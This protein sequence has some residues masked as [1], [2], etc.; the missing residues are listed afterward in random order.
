MDR[1]AAD[2]KFGRG[3]V[4]PL[5]Q[6]EFAPQL[7]RLSEIALMR[8]LAPLVL[9]VE[10]R[11]GPG[12]VPV[13]GRSFRE[14]KICTLIP[15]AIHELIPTIA[16]A[17]DASAHL[18]QP[19]G[20]LLA[21]GICHGGGL[22]PVGPNREPNDAQGMLARARREAMMG[23][24]S[25]NVSEVFAS[26]ELDRLEHIPNVGEM[27]DVGIVAAG[28]SVVALRTVLDDEGRRHRVPLLA[29][30]SL[31]PIN[32]S[33]VERL[34]E[35]CRRVLVFEPGG[36][37]LE[38]RVLQVAERMRRAARR[39]AEVLPG[40]PVGLPAPANA[41]PTAFAHALRRLDGVVESSPEPMSLEPP[42][43]GSSVGLAGAKMAVMRALRSLPEGAAIDDESAETLVVVGVDSN[44]FL[45][46]IAAHRDQPACFIGLDF[47]GEL[48]RMV[49]TRH[50][51]LTITRRT[52]Q[53]LDR[54]TSDITLAGR[55]NDI[56]VVMLRDEDPPRW[57]IEATRRRY[58]DLDRLGYA[59]RRRIFLPLRSISALGQG[60]EALSERVLSHRI[61]TAS[62]LEQETRT[63]GPTVEFRPLLQLVQVRREASPSFLPGELPEPPRPRLSD[64]RAFRL[65]FAGTRGP[66]GGLICE[67][68]ARAA[69][70]D[71]LALRW[72]HDS[73]ACGPGW[74]ASTQIVLSTTTKEEGLSPRIP[75]GCA[76]LLLGVE[77]AEA[78]R[79]VYGRIAKSDRTRAIVNGG[80]LRGDGTD[81]PWGELTPS[82]EALLQEHTQLSL[83]D[84]ATPARKTFGTDRAMD[85]MLL[86]FAYQRGEIPLRGAALQNAL[87]EVEREGFGR[88]E[89]AFLFGRSVACGGG[90]IESAETSS[91]RHRL[92]LER[93]LIKGGRWGQR[94]RH[95]VRRV[96]LAF[97]CF[98]ASDAPLAESTRHLILVSLVRAH[99]WGRA[100]VARSFADLLVSLAPILI[101]R[102]ERIPEVV[103]VLVRFLLPDDAIALATLGE[104]LEHRIRLR[105][106]LDLR[107]ARGDTVE[108]RYLTE[109]VL[110]SGDRQWRGRLRTGPGAA[111][112][113]RAMRVILPEWLRGAAND[114]ERKNL[115]R[116]LA[117]R[118]C[119]REQLD[120]DLAA[121]R[122]LSEADDPK[123]LCP[124]L[125]RD[126]I[127]P[128]TSIRV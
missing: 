36:S 32:E 68:M 57:D 109:V 119:R 18:Q 43:R 94:V 105:Q 53:D 76:D 100:S 28:E 98:D 59:T 14:L 81:R 125:I 41:Q 15:G 34:L 66:R 107:T 97:R 88:L 42:P 126:W 22:L 31:L 4:V 108:R 110:R 102:S 117:L 65:H 17:I 128:K 121:F 54:L 95:D 19:V 38:W 12:R 29:L 9:L 71:D 20:V 45:E 6:A 61:E 87:L 91:R 46:R 72:I 83:V 69:A 40:F 86:G 118:L 116:D 21:P 106:M 77:G 24:G 10:D 63:Q 37:G 13:P 79:A 73:T 112:S 23:G 84:L 39:P 85:M 3:A 47:D 11:P 115:V 123:S 7:Q 62:Q 101:E 67:V 49:R 50:T 111:R 75:D 48:E 44:R 30:R 96:N 124:K 26:M 60:A 103:Q 93:S 78:A 33:A 1:A 2:A 104:S 74:R 64:A 120:A 90:E 58:R 82:V 51:N 122:M 5:S 52:M 113:L 27:A 127:S 80:A 70:A 16:A 55:E 99:E 8:V 25:A 114:R 35:R 92:R 56:S 89:E